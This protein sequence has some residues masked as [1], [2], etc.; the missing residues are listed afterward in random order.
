[1]DWE[2]LLMFWKTIPQEKSQIRHR[3]AKMN[4]KNHPEREKG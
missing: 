3:L 2:K 4:E 1:M